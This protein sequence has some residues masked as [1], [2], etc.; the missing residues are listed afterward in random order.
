MTL[1][2]LELYRKAV[3][4]VWVANEYSSWYMRCHIVAISAR[5]TLCML[6]VNSYYNHT[7]PVSCPPGMGHFVTCAPSEIFKTLALV[8]ASAGTGVDKAND[9]AHYPHKCP[10][11][12]G[13]AYESFRTVDCKRGCK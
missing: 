6:E 1:D 2:E 7:S 10:R 5:L 9:N 3:W 11:C 13:P 8:R 4:P 12:G